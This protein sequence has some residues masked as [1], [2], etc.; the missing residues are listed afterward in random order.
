MVAQS[1]CTPGASVLILLV[2]T[3]LLSLA[4]EEG[5]TPE[6]RGS[7]AQ[8]S[9][10]LFVTIPKTTLASLDGAR[11]AVDYPLLAPVPD[12][13]EGKEAAPAFRTVQV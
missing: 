4:C 1:R 11:A 3:V 12:E 8:A 2:L 5:A 10:P 6:G 9:P 7:T 13:G